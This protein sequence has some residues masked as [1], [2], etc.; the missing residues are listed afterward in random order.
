MSAMNDTLIQPRTSVGSQEL[1][2]MPGRKAL[3]L[4]LVDDHDEIRNLLAGLLQKEDVIE[5]S[6]QFSSAEAMLKALAHETPP[7]VILTDLNMGGM[8]GIDSVGPVKAISSSTRVFVITT[9]YD[10]EKAAL[11]FKAGAAG[12]LLKRDDME[13][14]VRCIS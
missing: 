3:S 10:S 14:T 12:F 13:L 4:W 8:S 6:R 9:F 2:T 7:D 1:A 11:A 5:C